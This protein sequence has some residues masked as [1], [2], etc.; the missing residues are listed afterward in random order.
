VRRILEDLPESLDETYERILRDIR[1]PNQAYACRLLQCLVAAVRPLQVEELAEILAFDFSSDGIP[2]L[3]PGWRWEDQEEAVMS[4]CS[5]LV[6]VVK[7]GDSR[8]V[9]FSHFSV[10]EFLTSDRLARSGREEISRYH[11]PLD[12]AHTILAQACLGVLLKLG[13]KVVREDLKSFPLVKYATGNWGYH[14]QFKGVWSHIKDGC[15]S[16]LDTDKPHFAAFFFAYDALHG[17]PYPADYQ[18]GKRT[19]IY[20]AAAFGFYPLVEHLIERY[21]EDVNAQWANGTALHVASARGHVDVLLLLLQH[22]PVDIRSEMKHRTPL[23]CAAIKG[24][25]EVGRHLL[26]HGADMNAR[27]PDGR[28]SLHLAV[29]FGQLEFV[30]FLMEQGADQGVRDSYGE[31]PCQVA[32]RRGHYTILRLLSEYVVESEE[33]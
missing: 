32:K 30:R 29:H 23:H 21:P 2:K 1:R 17:P 7:D 11:I 18:K 19:P 16:L 24:N 6:I 25:V 28:T 27:E 20:F 15:E 5:S 9:Q 8:I 22:I 3:N 13:D 14:A 33:E 10:Q 12:V 4:A 31:T 26:N